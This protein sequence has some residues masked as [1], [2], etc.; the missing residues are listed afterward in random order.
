MPYSSKVMVVN[1][2][3]QIMVLRLNLLGRGWVES[4]GGLQGIQ[5]CCSRKGQNLGLKRSWTICHRK[6]GWADSSSR[7]PSPRRL[8]IFAETHYQTIF[9]RPTPPGTVNDVEWRPVPHKTSPIKEAFAVK[10]PGCNTCSFQISIYNS[11]V[12]FLLGSLADPIAQTP[13]TLLQ[14]LY[15][16]HR[17]T[18][19]GG[20]YA[21]RRPQRCS[22]QYARRPILRKG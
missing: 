22:S 18:G 6:R 8:T 17:T 5:L 16:R 7:L 14:L 11:P 4:G 2:M 13:L 9:S 10:P 19:I 15:N 21:S 3:G 1:F 12:F 20:D